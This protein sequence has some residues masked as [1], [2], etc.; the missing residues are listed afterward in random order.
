VDLITTTPEGE[1]LA[2]QDLVEDVRRRYK[3]IKIDVAEN[4]TYNLHPDTL[5]QR[6]SREYPRRVLCVEL[7]RQRLVRKWTPL[8]PLEVMPKRVEKMAEPLIAAVA[9]LFQPVTA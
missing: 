5:G 9:G 6:W 1:A 2:S 7:N 4:D 3:S 8:E